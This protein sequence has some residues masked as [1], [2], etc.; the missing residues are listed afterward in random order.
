MIGFIGGVSIVAFCIG[1]YAMI[2][3]WLVSD[4]VLMEYGA[5][6]TVAFLIVLIVLVIFTIDD[7]AREE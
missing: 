5:I 2:W 6:A 3:G 4:V 1:I 7:S